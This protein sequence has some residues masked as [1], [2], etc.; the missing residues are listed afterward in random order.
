MKRVHLLAETRNA[1][2]IGLYEWRE[3]SIDVPN[4]EGLEGEA[5]AERAAEHYRAIT[6]GE[7]DHRVVVLDTPENRRRASVSMQCEAAERFI[8]RGR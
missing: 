6:R 1:G 8:A 7:L 2:A 4:V 5:L 3:V